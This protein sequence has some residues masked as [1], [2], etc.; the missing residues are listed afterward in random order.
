[1][2]TTE[3]ELN[4]RKVVGLKLS[5]LISKESSIGLFYEVDLFYHEKYGS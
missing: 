1:M 2:K 4:G 3:E 5:V